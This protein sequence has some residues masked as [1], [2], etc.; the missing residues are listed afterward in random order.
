MGLS[1]YFLGLHHRF[2]Q[3]VACW[4]SRVVW[5]SFM[6]LTDNRQT[7]VRG[8]TR[9]LSTP[10]RHLS[11]KYH[12]YIRHVPHAHQTYGTC[13]VYMWYLSDR[14]LVGVDRCLVG[15]ASDNRLTGTVKYVGM[16]DFLNFKVSKPVKSLLSLPLKASTPHTIQLCGR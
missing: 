1:Y 2:N 7:I 5:C 4:W 10:T 9:H 13:L 3:A 6:S 15:Q 16:E 11:D 12:I 8:P 14:C